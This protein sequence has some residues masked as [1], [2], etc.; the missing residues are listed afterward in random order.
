MITA[1]GLPEGLVPNLRE[2][3]SKGVHQQPFLSCINPHLPG[4]PHSCSKEEGKVS[5]AAADIQHCVACLCFCPLD[6]HPLPHSVLPQTQGVVQ[7][8]REQTLMFADT[9]MV[10][11][12]TGA[13]L[14]RCSAVSFH[15]ACLIIDRSNP[16]KELLS[17][18]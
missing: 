6:S 2:M 14:R 4:G 8:Q 9:A 17:G 1:S 12:N 7:L 16:A 15:H 18:L 13:S 11:G 10:C 5:T 3:S